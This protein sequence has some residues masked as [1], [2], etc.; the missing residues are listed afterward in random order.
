MKYTIEFRQ[1]VIA[2]KEKYGLTLRETARRFDISERALL[3]W[4]KRIE[5]IRKYNVKNRINLELLKQ[6]VEAYPDAYQYE[7][8]ERLKS[9]Q[10]SVCRGLKELGITYKK[11]R[12]SI[13]KETKKRGQG[14]ESK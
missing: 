5:P 7:R 12:W 13:R 3:R 1:K 9:S 8:A 6:D 2:T 11:K 4:N 10:S 14:I